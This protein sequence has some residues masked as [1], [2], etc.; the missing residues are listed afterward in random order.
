MTAV[1]R[2]V[3]MIITRF[4]TLV[5]L[6]N[7][8]VCNSF[9]QTVIEHE[10]FT[11]KLTFNIF[12]L[13]LARIFDDSTFKLKYVFETLMFEISTGFFTTDSAG[14]IHQKVFIFFK[15]L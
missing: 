3:S 5:A 4:S 12:F 7:Y 9:P 8:I 14:T 2:A 6:G 13:D 1:I 15:I 10:I 11:D